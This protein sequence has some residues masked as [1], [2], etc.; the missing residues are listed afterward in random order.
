[1]RNGLAETKWEEEYLTL[2]YA[3]NKDELWN[4]LK[5][6]MYDLRDQFVPK[7]TISGSIPIEKPVQE[8]ILQITTSHRRWMSAKSR[9][10]AQVARLEYTKAQNNGKRL[11]RKAEKR[12]CKGDLS[13]TKKKPEDFL[14][15]CTTKTGVAPLLEDW[16]TIK[17][18]SPRNLNTKTKQIFSGG[19]S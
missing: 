14:L 18:R 11:M 4:R 10:D 3:R 19:N 17:T 13:Q 16:Q 5:S 6:K 7:T 12:I 15:V 2:G 9:T 8:A 1:M